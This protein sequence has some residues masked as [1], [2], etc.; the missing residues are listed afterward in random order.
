LR[1]RLSAMKKFVSSRLMRIKS[2]WDWI[3]H[4]SAMDAR[5]L[6]PCSYACYSLEFSSTISLS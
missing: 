5:I 3:A 6:S 1:Q 4:E 2:L